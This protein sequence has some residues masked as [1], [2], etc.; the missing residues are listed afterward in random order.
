MV[1]QIS[2]G[3]FGQYINTVPQ[4]KKRKKYRILFYYISVLRDTLL[5]GPLFI[6]F[7][8]LTSYQIAFLLIPEQQVPLKVSEF[9]VLV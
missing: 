3:Q 9:L 8:E 6:P 4:K 2:L 7:C 1:I 5:E